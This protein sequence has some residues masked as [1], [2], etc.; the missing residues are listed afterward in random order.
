MREIGATACEGAEQMD[1]GE[2]SDRMRGSRATGV[3]GA[4]QL[5]QDEKSCQVEKVV[6]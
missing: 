6:K 3:G 5:V 1:E 2:R 4:E